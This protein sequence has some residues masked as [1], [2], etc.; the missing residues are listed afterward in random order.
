MPG[1]YENPWD[2]EALLDSCLSQPAPPPAPLPSVW[3][4]FRALCI[5]VGVIA[6]AF[7]LLFTFMY[8]LHYSREPG[9][10]PAVKDGDLV[11][12]YRLDRKYRP[13]DLLLLTFQKQKQVRRV[14]AVA[15]DTVDIAEDGLLING[16][17][18]QER[19]IYQ[20]TRRYAEG[21]DFPLTLKANEVFVLGDARENADDSRIY[22]PVNVRDTRGTVIT[23]L[24]RRNL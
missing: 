1:V 24:R 17:L 20:K 19:G 2:I 8:G 18:Q 3:K 9:M 16:S 4:E 7:A 21:T 12:F 5:K 15:G 14:V 6:A 13:G 10:V 22:G 23:I 11:L